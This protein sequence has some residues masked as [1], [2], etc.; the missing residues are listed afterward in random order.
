MKLRP[1]QQ[2]AV[3]NV[4]SE[5]ETNKSTL[6][7]LPTGGGKTV[8]FSK[9][10]E[11]FISS[12]RVM[13]IAHREE[14]I[15]QAAAKIHAITGYHPAVEMASEWSAEDGFSKPKIVVSSVQTLC[16]G[17]V[18]RFD[19]NEFSLLITDECFPAGT[20][21]DGKPIE[22]IEVGDVVNSV[23]HKTGRIERKKVTSK[24]R[25]TTH[26]P[27]VDVKLSD[28]RTVTCT[29]G[30][31]FWTPDGYVS[32]MSLLRGSMVATIT[33]D[34]IHEYLY[35]LPSQVHRDM[36]Q[37]DVFARVPHR[38]DAE[39]SREVGRPMLMVQG[40]NRAT[41]TA[42]K[43]DVQENGQSVLWQRVP[44]EVDFKELFHEHGKDQQQGRSHSVG[45][46]EE[47]KPDEDG[48]REGEGIN[49]TPRYR[50]EADYSQGKWSRDDCAR[51]VVCISDRME[52]GLRQDRGAYG[53]WVS[54][55]LQGGCRERS[56]EDCCRDRREFTQGS[57]SSAA[58]QEERGTVEVAWVESVSV[59]ER[60]SG[61]GC[62]EVCAGSVVFNLEVEDNHNYFANGILV[63]NCHHSTAASYSSVYAHMLSGRCKHLGVT[64]T[65]DRA[66]EQALGKVYQTVAYDYELPQII[67]DGWLV[68]I[69]QRL[70]TVTGLNYSNVKTTAGDLNQG[71]VAAAQANE[72][73]LHEMI[74]PI[75]ELAGTRKTIVFATPG[76]K[77]PTESDDGF[78]IAERMT[79]IINRY[80]PNSARRVSQDT[81]KDVR[82]QMLMDFADGKFQY[83]VNVGVLT[84]GFDDPSIEVVAITR[85]TKSRSLFA[86]MIGRGTRPLPGVVD[87]YEHAHERRHAIATSGKPHIEVLDFVGNSGRHKLIT[88]ADILGGKYEQE[89]IDRAEKKAKEETVD[90]SEA[91]QE[92]HDE[93]KAEREKAKRAR[94]LA[95]TKFKV[96]S[97]D[98][99][100]VFDIQPVRERQWDI[101]KPPTTAQLLALQKLGIP[102]V[103]DLSRSRAGQ[104]LSEA[105][106]R[107]DEGLVSF[108]QIAKGAK[109]DMKLTELNQDRFKNWTVKYQN[110]VSPSGQ[111]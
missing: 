61:A 18:M 14:L 87:L 72:T 70:V 41:I 89:V 110:V 8:V 55:L 40:S 37:K 47:A 22:T 53:A 95:Q 81:P 1:Y 62:D 49:Q 10:T 101:G 76:S 102:V 92:A 12:G 85:P 26:T 34:H 67:A 58:G 84:E 56:I 79:E 75:V 103:K 25:N 13:V 36:Q 83:L 104:L 65:P 51:T 91:L 96:E 35:S 57:V 23:N 88:T 16:T 66:D 27:L 111:P 100:D 69:K 7:V 17:R 30:H 71:D 93:L 29:P 28:G 6:L 52:P 99:F 19:P 106:R 3:D 46:N 39:P 50:M 20:L 33:H 82:R 60:A 86:Q 77:K 109:P 5:L 97:V 9:I 74:H 21:V 31:P 24:M 32:A 94:I 2:H 73:I 45:Q 63:H 38:P 98:P 11:H 15:R 105:Y 44:S 64:A 48:R 108:K 59:H 90:M 68:P 107:V 78:H 80:K 42:R 4:I 54:H 43:D